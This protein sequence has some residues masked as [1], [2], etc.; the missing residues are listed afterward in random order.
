MKDFINQE[1]APGHVWRHRAP[2]GT[3]FDFSPNIQPRD[4][5]GELKTNF[6]LTKQYAPQFSQMG[7]QELEKAIMG[8]SASGT[9][10][11]LD[12]FQQDIA[13]GFAAADRAAST[14]QREQ[15]IADVTRLGAGAVDAFRSANPQQKALVDRLN[16]EAMAGLDAGYNLPPGLARQVTQSARG[17]QAARGMGFGPSDAYGET[18]AN[19]QA[20]ADFYG[21]NFNRAQQVAGLNA[22]TSGDPMQLVTG[23]ASGAGG[24]NL[25]NMGQQGSQSGISNVLGLTSGILDYNANADA[26]RRIIGSQNDAGFYGGMMSY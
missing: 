20:A 25:L 9:R 16:T 5:A 7:R 26:S 3:R 15:D 8:D 18:L 4:V 17:A 23:R 19:S 6:E 11:L 2:A 12:I 14:A 10:G 1:F 24:L 22:A 21:Q 13:P